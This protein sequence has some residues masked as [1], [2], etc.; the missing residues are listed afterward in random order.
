LKTAE[1]VVFA[2][3]RSI[4]EKGGKNKKKITKTGTTILEKLDLVFY[5]E[6]IRSFYM[7]IKLTRTN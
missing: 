6:K 7:I 2:K 3:E 5:F 4:I 1:L